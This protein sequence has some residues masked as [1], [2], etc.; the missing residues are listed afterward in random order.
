[1]IAKIKFQ[2]EDEK[3]DY[4]AACDSDFEA[5]LDDI[6]QT[7]CSEPDL[8]YVTLSGPTCSGK[9]TA[10]RKL[11][12]EFKERG[13]EV[14]TVSLDDFFKNRSVLEAEA[15]AEGRD[16]DFDSERALDLPALKAFIDA[17]QEGRPA[18]LPKFDF[19][20]GKRVST[21]DFLPEEN[22]IILFE[23]IQAIYPV[24]TN[25]I[26]GIPCVSLI[27]NVEDSLTVGNVTLPPR[28]VR[29]MRRLVRDYR[30]RGADPVFSFRL[31]EGV[32][33]NEDKNILPFTDNADF[34]INSLLGY[35]ACMLKPYL[36]P[37]LHTV[38]ADSLYRK[39]ADELLAALDGIDTVSADYLPENALY[40]E[41]I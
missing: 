38:P 31:W 2:S 29:L 7:V 5:R 37:L 20:T 15:K 35:E 1:M 4:V 33:A 22:D 6:M 28:T 30:F 26:K 10:S 27:I 34:H 8:H 12:S 11:I 19:V 16:V 9:T 17:L 21:E 23:G 18:P 39:K 14:K 40:K 36:E 24:F 32:T 25:M 13:K 41:F 3:R